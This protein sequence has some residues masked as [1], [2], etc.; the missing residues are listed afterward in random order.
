MNLSLS[1]KYLLPFSNSFDQ[2]TWHS[3]TVSSMS[4]YGCGREDTVCKRIGRIW[5]GTHMLIEQWSLDHKLAT[6]LLIEMEQYQTHVDFDAYMYRWNLEACKLPA[7][8]G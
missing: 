7:S 1:S 6:L 4:L 3:L 5:K 2:E 8:T